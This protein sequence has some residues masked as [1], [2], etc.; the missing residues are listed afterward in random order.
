MTSNRVSI[1]EIG[2]K[3]RMKRL[4]VGDGHELRIVAPFGYTGP[5]DLSLDISN[6]IYQLVCA[7]ADLVQEL[8]TFGPYATVRTELINACPVPY[9][10]VLAYEVVDVCL[11]DPRLT[12]RRVEYHTIDVLQRQIAQGIDY[13]TVHASLCE[14]LLS[15]TSEA[16]SKRAIPIPSRAGGML[17]TLMRKARC[18]NPFSKLFKKIADTCSEASVV[19][20]LG[21]SLR[22]AAISDANDQAQVMEI[23]EQ[24]RLAQI[25]STNNCQTMLEGISHA[26]PGDLVTYCDV[27][28]KYCPNTPITALGPLPIDVAAGYDHVAAAIGVTFGRLAGLALV[29]VV[30][31]KEHLAMPRIK[32]MIEAIRSARVGA[33]VADAMKKGK[34]SEQDRMMSEARSSLD[35]GA[36]NTFALFK[37]LFH[38]IRAEESLED[39]KPCSICGPKCPFLLG[40]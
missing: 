24:G 22:S 34:N 4:Y 37:D 11:R 8:S 9:G 26:L 2:G 19:I 3:R 10:T 32:D 29:N 15:R 12:A 30:S 20:S 25:A 16:R 33:Y 31:S 28:R 7:G 1:I 36:Q 14:E 27:A 5:H 23:Q 21:S 18:D 13:S 35:W 6:H 38:A 40:L 39:N 17:I